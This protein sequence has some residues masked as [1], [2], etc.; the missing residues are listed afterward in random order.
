MFRD[1][2]PNQEKINEIINYIDGKG[3]NTEDL[4]YFEHN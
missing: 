4:E 3:Y 2:H 1:A